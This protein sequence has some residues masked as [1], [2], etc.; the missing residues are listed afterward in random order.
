[1]II[2]K[3]SDKKPK[4]L[5]FQGS[6]RDKDTCPNMISKTHKIIDHIYS[7]WSTFID[8][9][10]IDLS[11]NLSKKSNIQPCKGCV[12]T[13]GGY[14]CHFPCIPS[15]ERVQTEFGYENINYIKAGDILS[16]GLV[17]SQ[18]MTSPLE[19][20]YEIVLSDGRK[21]RLTKNHKIKILS[22][23]R[24][25]NKSTNWKYF[26]VEEWKELKDIKIHD[27][28]PEIN[29]GGSFC[30]KTKFSNEYF[31]LSGIFWGD[32]T[33]AGKDSLI[34]YYDDRTEHDMGES[35]NNSEMRKINYGSKIGRKIQ[36]EMGFKKTQPAIKRRLPKI[37]FNCSEEELCLF[38]NG[39]FST[40]GTIS[41]GVSLCNVSY[42]CLRD[43]QLLLAKLGI[44]SSVTNNKKLFSIIR[45]KKCAR[46]STLDIYGYENVKIFKE[47]IGFINDSKKYKLDVYLSLSRNK[48][49][50]KPAFVKSI[51]FVGKESVYDI[52]VN[53]SHEFVA[54]GILVHNCDCYFKNDTEAPDLMHNADIYSLLQ[55]CDVFI[56]VSPIH[57]YSL[58]SQ[59]K[60]L[61]D[62]L[63]C[64]SQSLT[65]EDARKL[66]G[67]DIKNS[68][69]TGKFAHSGKHD[70]ML[71]NHLEGKIAGFY[72]HGDDGADDYEGKKLPESYDIID[73]GFQLNPIN[74]IAPFITQLKYSGIF[75]PNELLQAFYINKG[76]NYYDS[77]LKIKK[78]FFERADVLMENLLNYLNINDQ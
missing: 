29:L 50:N 25:R 77:N 65:V 8:F 11:I 64:I 34:I 21:L 15:S 31:L 45:N 67:K 4:V 35:I 61:F 28:V 13:S 26:R 19:D 27:F 18:W 46:S 33:I 44:K 41:K 22:K 9:K 5:L 59:L 17:N 49:K 78:E 2:R 52:T 7:K 3:L 47:K 40:D 60:T 74:V 12:S 51:N 66:L 76:I 68:E 23:E 54:E 24:Y 39:W 1:M 16:T 14:H 70:D 57:W 20:I 63:V 62:R 72:V 55:W 69:V 32:G 53:D 37:L 75:V 30:E 48:M 73:D 56:I 36:Y 10:I 6:T 71:R 43:A 42:D 58:T 38:F